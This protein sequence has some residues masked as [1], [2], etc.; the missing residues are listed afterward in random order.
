M[1]VD[2]EDDWFPNMSSRAPVRDRDRMQ[3][4]RTRRKGQSGGKNSAMKLLKGWD[5]RFKGH[6]KEDPE[7][8]L[9]RLEACIRGADETDEEILCAMRCVLEDKAFIWFNTISPYISTWEE[10]KRRFRQQYAIEYNRADLVDDLNRRTQARG[11]R[12]TPFINS[13]RYIVTRF[14][15]PPTERE[16]MET[17]YRNLLPEYR[18]AMADKVVVSLDDIEMYGQCWERQKELNARLCRLHP[19]IK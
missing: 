9:E 6:S 13:L 19:L 4:P 16:L 1:S 3:E 14:K 12:I 5:I 18:R 11:E 2:S 17:A 10:F 7:A 8:F 15:V